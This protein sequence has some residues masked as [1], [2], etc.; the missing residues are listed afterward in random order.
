MNLKIKFKPN[1]TLKLVVNR[2]EFVEAVKPLILLVQDT[3]E[4]AI[5]AVKSKSEN[6][7]SDILDEIVLVGGSSRI[8]AIQ[9]AMRLACE[10]YDIFT[11][12]KMNTKTKV[13]HIPRAFCTSISPE[14]AVVE[15]LAIKGAILA[16]ENIH[17]LKNILMIDCLPTSIGII[18]HEN[19]FKIFEP[20]LLQGSRIPC[21]VSKVFQI[22]NDYQR[23]VSLEIYE[24][25]EESQLTTK[26]QGPSKSVDFACERKYSYHLLVTA[27]VPIYN[28]DMDN[29]SFQ[30]TSTDFLGKK[31][32]RYAE[33]TFKVDEDG[34]LSYDVSEIFNYNPPTSSD[35]DDSNDNTIH[36]L[37]YH[38]IAN[39]SKVTY[40]TALQSWVLIMFIAILLLL[41]ISLKVL[42]PPPVD[43]IGD[44][45]D[46]SPLGTVIEQMTYNLTSES[47]MVQELDGNLNDALDL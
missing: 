41:Y 40:S 47:V 31:K 32:Y 28:H 43:V 1:E 14:L 5:Q 9:D 27:D 29:I 46:L 11:F 21:Q 16:G 38:D 36:V 24:E 7:V 6:E 42:F 26:C 19:G 4:M 22:A 17:V 44:E 10:K 2:D 12:S 8:P 45:V 20:I 25:M 3:V 23:F 18:S 34:Q 30:D 33:V 13:Q 35:L 39:K 15:G 37:P